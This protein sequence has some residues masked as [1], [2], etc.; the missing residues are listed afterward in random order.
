MEKCD[1]AVN[2]IIDDILSFTEYQ[3]PGRICLMGD[4]IDLIDLPV[5]G[6]A[7]NTLLTIKIRRLNRPIIKLYSENFDSWLEYPLGEKGDWEHPLKYWCALAYRLKGKIGG[8]EAHVSSEIPIGSG[9]SS[10]AAISIALARGLNN[11]FNLG[12]GHLEI[13]ELAYQ[14]EHTDL[15]IA[16]GRLDQYS[17]ANGGISFIET[18]ETPTVTPLEIKTLPVVVGDTQEP[19]NAKHILNTLKERLDANDPLYH[20]C[21][22]TVHD[23]VLKGKEALLKGDYTTI[24]ALMNIQQE[25][26]NIMGAATEKLN[27]LCEVSIKAGALGAKQMGAG[28]GGCIVAVCPGKQ[29]EVADA[30]N[31]AGGRAWI[32][33]IYNY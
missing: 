23:C 17:I 30:I 21:M 24:G 33:D 13:A 5:I 19:R 26:E 11:I 22:S 29:K 32:F 7:V 14:A 20:K 27:L 6:C 31:A 8:F 1:S 15:G 12:M 4:K 10:S 18:G 28:G 2:T 9:L 3:I 25:Q 16:C